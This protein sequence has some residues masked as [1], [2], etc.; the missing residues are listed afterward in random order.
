MSQRQIAEGIKINRS[1]YGSY[2]DGRAEPSINTFISLSKFYGIT[3]DEMFAEVIGAIP[4]PLSNM[5]R[6]QIMHF[7]KEI[8]KLLTD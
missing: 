5:D 7:T 3:L 8:Q 6:Q 1:A 4:V 2:E